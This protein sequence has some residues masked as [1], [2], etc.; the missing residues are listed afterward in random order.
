M[1]KF[2]LVFLAL[3]LLATL[4][5]C[6]KSDDVTFKNE[7]GVTIHSIYIS[8]VTEDQ[9]PDPLNY[10]RLN[11]GSQIHIDFEK[12]AAEG[13]TLY[14]VAAVD[15]NN[16][17]YDIFDVPLAVGDILALSANGETAILTVTGTNGSTKTYEGYAYS[18][19]EE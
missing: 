6:G 17:N 10:A 8:P 11:N 3:A 1:K 13:T 12:F 9:W 15:E 2:L 5:A 14:D 19:S 7:L 16:M 4:C 18:G